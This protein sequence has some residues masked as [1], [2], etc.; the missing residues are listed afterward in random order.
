MQ[1]F[2]GQVTFPLF[3]SLKQAEHSCAQECLFVA[4]LKS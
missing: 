1:F 2:L 4:A 3:P